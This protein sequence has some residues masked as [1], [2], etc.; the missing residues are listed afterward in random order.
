MVI[1]LLILLEPTDFTVVMAML[2][3]FCGE[4]KQIPVDKKLGAVVVV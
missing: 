4:G 3:A 2:L 1:G